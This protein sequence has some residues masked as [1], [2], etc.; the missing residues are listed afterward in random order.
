M[1]VAKG[2]EPMN[3]AERS[4]GGWRMV[5]SPS[6]WGMGLEYTVEGRLD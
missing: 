4:V 3:N 5:T 6:K 2:T 1:P